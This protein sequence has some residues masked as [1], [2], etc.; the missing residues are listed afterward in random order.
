MLKQIANHFRGYLKIKITGY[1]PERFLNLCKN[2]EIWIWDLESCSDAYI[3]YI[4]MRD[5]KKLKPLLRK[6]K[7]KIEILEKY[8]IPFYLNKYKKRK[9]FLGGFFLS[10]ILI[11][12]LSLFVWNIE[13]D[14]NS[15]IT[16]EVIIEYL[17]SENVYHGMWKNKVACETIGT[18][19]RKEFN[20]I[21]WVSVSLE[22]SNIIIQ[23]KENADTFEAESTGEF[24]SDIIATSDGI[25]TEIITRSGVPCVAVGDT[26]KKGDI[27]VSGNIEVKNDAGETIREEYREADA[28]IYAEVVISYDDFCSDTYEVKQ[29]D[30]NRHKYIYLNIGD[31]QIGFGIRKNKTDSY[32]IV[33]WHD[34]ITLNA[35]F[36]IPICYGEIIGNGYKIIEQKYSEE[37]KKQLLEKN[38]EVFCKKLEENDAIVLEKNINMKRENSGIRASGY[39][40]VKQ[41][42]G[43]TRKSIDF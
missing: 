32:D 36:K 8:G 15:T 12:C 40:T 31:Y 37:K 2:K 10:I 4:A 11:Y 16:D 25:I 17:E 41:P 9:L 23:V 39:L 6:T 3:M 35:N 18:K 24:P 1:S 26:V 28:D 14:G 33:S 21:I 5:F 27:L 30:R 38:I 34:Q 7:T 43:S 22:G 19:L 42:I 20:D 29:Y 13:I